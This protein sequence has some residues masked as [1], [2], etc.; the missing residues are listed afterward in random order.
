MDYWGVEMDILQPPNN[1]KIRIIKQNFSFRSSYIGGEIFTKSI[2]K[3]NE[4]SILI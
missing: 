1:D 2:G 4:Q 3:K